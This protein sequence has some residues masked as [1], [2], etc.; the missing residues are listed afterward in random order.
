MCNLFAVLLDPLNSDVEIKL[1]N[2]CILILYIG[3][4]LVKQIVF[5]RLGS[6]LASLHGFRV[7]IVV[8]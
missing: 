7:K 2:L 5:L 4:L 8:S 3:N 1:A 6:V